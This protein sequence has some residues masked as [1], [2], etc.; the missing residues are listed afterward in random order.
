MSYGGVDSG[1]SHLQQTQAQ[2]KK[3]KD[4][5][6]KPQKGYKNSTESCPIWSESLHDFETRIMIIVINNCDYVNSI[7]TLADIFLDVKFNKNLLIFGIEYCHEKLCVH[8]VK[9][10]IL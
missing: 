3:L 4:I 6:L 9:S 2:V 1:N 5:H 7:V 8:T 10:V